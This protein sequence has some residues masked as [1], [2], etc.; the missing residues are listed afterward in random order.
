M[1]EDEVTGGDTNPDWYE[2][3]ISYFISQHQE[4]ESAIDPALASLGPTQT[5]LSGPSTP[6]TSTQQSV[7]NPIINSGQSIPTD[8][9]PIRKGK[10]TE[11]NKPRRTKSATP[12]ASE[13]SSMTAFAKQ[14]SNQVSEFIAETRAS[15]QA[16]LMADSQAINHSTSP[17]TQNASVPDQF[18][19][20]CEALAI[21]MEMYKDGKFSV[22][23]VTDAIALL[24]NTPIHCVTFVGLMGELREGWLKKAISTKAQ[25]SQVM[26]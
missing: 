26:N 1:A 11:S 20:Y 25:Q 21:L 16:C 12:V 18:Q 4:L 13:K 7:F 24:E 9:T 6:S 23:E 19:P 5:A 14:I 10:S 22:D 3:D 17:A 8:A 2:G 15:K